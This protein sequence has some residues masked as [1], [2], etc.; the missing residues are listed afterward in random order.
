[1]R[2]HCAASQS[3]HCYNLFSIY[4]SDNLTEHV[5]C[6]PLAIDNGGSLIVNMQHHSQTV[7]VMNHCL[8]AYNYCDMTYP[9][10]YMPLNIFAVRLDCN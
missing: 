8:E 5:Q 2:S 6:S 3:T 1:M 4:S 9:L 10:L 7:F